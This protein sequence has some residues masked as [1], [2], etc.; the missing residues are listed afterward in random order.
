MVVG[1]AL[2]AAPAAVHAQ[3][4]GV[5]VGHYLQGDDWTVFKVGIDRP[6]L[7]PLAIGLYGTHFRAASDTG[8]RLWGAGADLSLFREGRQGPYVIGGL[9][10]GFATQSAHDFWGSWSAGAGYQLVPLS[11]LALSAE[12]RW[13]ELT[14]G[15]RG[16]LEVSLRLGGLFGGGPRQTAP[17][18]SPPVAANRPGGS[19]LPRGPDTAGALA[20]DTVASPGAPAAAPV[21]LAT[22][23]RLS[24]AATLADSVVGT[25]AAAMGTAYRLG[26]TTTDG[27]D[28]SGLIQYAYGRY[29]VI[30]PRTSAE[31]ARAGEQIAR[32]LPDLRP[33]DILTFSNAGG[34]VTHVGL[35]VGDGHFIH[36]AT[37]GVQLSLLSPDD[38]YGK[39]WWAR[40]VGARRVVGGER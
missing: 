22:V 36:S 20:A 3:G 17:G 16:G 4:A 21:P 6:L 39:W 30:L 1:A 23:G 15:A 2:A 18:G 29:G 24:D 26:G 37:R 13:R 11:F 33:G 25:V 8:E 31:Q 7:G 12:A 32:R 9:G 10:G 14:P 38:P 34:R 5:E 19:V 35:Y 27:F 28:C 40:W